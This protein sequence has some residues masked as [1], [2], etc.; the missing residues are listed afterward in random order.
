MCSSAHAKA[1]LIQ[2][3]ELVNGRLVH[4]SHVVPGGGGITAD[5]L[6]PSRLRMYYLNYKVDKKF[7]K[8][9]IGNYGKLCKY[10]LD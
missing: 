3:V 2:V 5:R 1:G 4:F 7:Y 8:A 6:L 10:F 9:V